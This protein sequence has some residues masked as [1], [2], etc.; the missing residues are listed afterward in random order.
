MPPGSAN[1]R[2]SLLWCQRQRLYA[3]AKPEGAGHV[4]PMHFL[5]FLLA[6]PPICCEGRDCDFKRYVVWQS[7]LKATQ[8]Q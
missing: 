8:L 1:T 3:S 7:R 2:R 6:I 5:V 4:M